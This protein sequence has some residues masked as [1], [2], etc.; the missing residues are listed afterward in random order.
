MVVTAQQLLDVEN[1]H[2]ALA[3]GVISRVKGAGVAFPL[4]ALRAMHNEDVAGALRL[5]PAPV[6]C[7]ALQAF[8]DF[9]HRMA[10]LCGILNQ[11][12]TSQGSKAFHKIQPDMAHNSCCA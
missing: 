5:D 11:G 4:A 7:F 9:Q 3:C 1:I 6:N 2:H 8:N 10:T 12:Y